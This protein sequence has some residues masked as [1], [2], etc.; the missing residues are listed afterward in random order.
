MGTMLLDRDLAGYPSE[1]IEEKKAELN[2]AQAKEE[3]DEQPIS[4]T[5]G[6]FLEQGYPLWFKISLHSL[7]TLTA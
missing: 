6:C 7:L 4:E 2:A 1:I 3:P 5:D